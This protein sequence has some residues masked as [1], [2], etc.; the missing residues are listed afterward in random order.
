MFKITKINLKKEDKEDSKMKAVASVVIDD[1]F[2]IE[3]LRIIKSVK[4]DK[5]FVAFPSRRKKDETFKDI[6]HPLDKKTRELFEKAILEKYEIV[7]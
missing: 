4:E 3:D 7:E 2:I 6:C 5:L 1:C